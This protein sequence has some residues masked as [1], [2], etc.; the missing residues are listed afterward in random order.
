VYRQTHTQFF[1]SHSLVSLSAIHFCSSSTLIQ[2]QP[3]SLFAYCCNALQCWK[4]IVTSVI[5][6]TCADATYCLPLRE[7]REDWSC[8]AERDIPDLRER[9]LGRNK[10]TPCWDSYC[11]QLM[12]T[13]LTWTVWVGFLI[14]RLTLWRIHIG[15]VKSI[16][17]Y[18]FNCH[19]LLVIIS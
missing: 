11:A 1:G 9:G 6:T 4:Q 12:R 13:A 17:F 7:R 16:S 18:H 5:L 15:H 14:S 19:F 8:S 10:V 2:A 3:H